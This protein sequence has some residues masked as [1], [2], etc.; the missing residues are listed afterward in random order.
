VVPII[1]NGTTNGTK[2]CTRSQGYWKTHSVYGNKHRD[3]TWDLI[4]P[5]AEDTPFFSCG[6]S[7]YGVLVHH[8]SP[9][10]NLGRQ[11]VAATLN[12]L[13]GSFQPPNV[14]QAYNNATLLFQTHTAEQGE[15]DALTKAEKDYWEQLKN[16]LEA[17][18]LI[19]CPDDNGED[20]KNEPNDD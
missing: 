5:D 20:D 9:Y 6:C 4:L 11:Y 12:F 7:W 16:I 3:D 18:N 14:V 15:K 19:H 13:M 17:Y 8:P 2:N 1:P 10:F